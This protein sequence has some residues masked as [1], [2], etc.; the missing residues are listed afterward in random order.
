MKIFILLYAILLAACSSIEYEKKYEYIK[1]E[2]Y[3]H[4]ENFR[5]FDFIIE[6]SLENG[7][8][9]YSYSGIYLGNGLEE[10]P[11]SEFLNSIEISPAIISRSFDIDSEYPILFIL[12]SIV[13]NM[14]PMLNFYGD[15]TLE[16]IKYV[17]KNAGIFNFPI[18]IS[19]EINDYFE[20][21]REMFDR[22]SPNSYIVLNMYGKHLDYNN[23]H[24]ISQYVDWINLN[25]NL[26]IDLDGNFDYSFKKISIFNFLF[27]DKNPLMIS[28]AVS[29]HNLNNNTH[30]AYQASLKI[31]YIYNLISRYPR[32]NAIIYINKLDI[33]AA[34]NS[35]LTNSN[36]TIKAH[37]N[38]LNLPNIVN[39]FSKN[40]NR[41]TLLKSIFR[42]YQI[43]G[44]FYIPKHPLI[45]RM[46]IDL[47]YFK[48]FESKKYINYTQFVDMRE[49]YKIL[50]L[51]FFVIDN[52]NIFILRTK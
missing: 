44:V 35:M 19:F 49:V 7:F 2:S 33:N 24:H 6:K 34:Q 38:M 41:N 27:Q 29:N 13:N 3:T 30:F 1:G 31:E 42:V 26:N 18:F 39:N 43:D 23:I 46:D 28:V 9:L 51:D 45:Y 20:K 52:R 50:G 25:L 32:I 21:I 47:K 8:N 11:I 10:M 40:I 5:A 14:A 12:E 4:I 37:K 15:Y 22:Y 48:N 17:A 16:R 36:L